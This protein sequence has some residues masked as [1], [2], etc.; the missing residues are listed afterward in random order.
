[1]IAESTVKES[2]SS[3]RSK[4]LTFVGNWEAKL[5]C[6]PMLATEARSKKYLGNIG[7]NSSTPMLKVN[8]TDVENLTLFRR[9]NK[10]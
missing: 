10:E 2:K 6:F 8:R 1:M 9:E 7:V 3:L 5:I 4:V